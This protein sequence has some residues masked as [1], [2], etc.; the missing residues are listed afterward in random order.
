M[1]YSTGE[2]RHLSTSPAEYQNLAESDCDHLLLKQY[3]Q[4]K[5]NSYRKG[6]DGKWLLLSPENAAGLLTPL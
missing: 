2:D 5:L 3:L 1:D 6:K 4:V